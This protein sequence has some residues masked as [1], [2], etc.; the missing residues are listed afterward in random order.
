[1]LDV[2]PYLVTGF[3]ERLKNVKTWMMLSHHLYC[4]RDSQWIPVWS[5]VWGVG[6]F[7]KYANI[8]TIVHLE[9]RMPEE[10]PLAGRRFLAYREEDA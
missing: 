2:I 8:K 10:S 9:I 5:F 6:I 3:S 7:F 4:L 1:M